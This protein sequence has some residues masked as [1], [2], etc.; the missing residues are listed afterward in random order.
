[1]IKVEKMSPLDQQIS[2][3]SANP[4]IPRLFNNQ[5]QKNPDAIA[6]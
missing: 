1:M 6:S 2:D 5:A 3:L 4:C